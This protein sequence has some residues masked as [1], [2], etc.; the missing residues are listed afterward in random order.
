MRRNL[1][2]LNALRTLEAAGRHGSFTDAATELGVTPGAVSRQIKHLESIVGFDLFQ[3]RSGGLEPTEE[4]RQFVGSLGQIFDHMELASRRLL[5][6]GGNQLHVSC[7]MT[8]TVCWLVT[9]MPEFHA[10]HPDWELRFTAALPPPGTERNAADIH[11]RLGDGDGFGPFSE[12]LMPNEL[13]PVVSPSLLENGPPLKKPADLIGY[14]LLHSMVRP[15]H[16]PNW[17]GA[18]GTDG[19]NLDAGIRLATS[20]LAYQAAI[21]GLGV[22]IGQAAMVY[23][24]LKAG[25]LVTPFRRIVVDRDAFH[26]SWD[27]ELASPR[28]QAF[29]DWG[30]NAAERHN[31]AVADYT[32]AYERISLSR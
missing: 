28:V 5:G 15:Q 20:T 23:E 17:L 7:S 27:P 2:P 32:A 11:I 6:N 16:W 26:L 14:T 24:H 30:M 4:C 22:A 13:V 3:R 9:R 18:T 21:E 19:I 10:L 8:F 25:R 31:A 29:R 12:W 1:P